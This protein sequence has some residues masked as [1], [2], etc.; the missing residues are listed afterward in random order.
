M[1]QKTIKLSRIK[2][3]QEMK[4]TMPR[5]DKLAHK[6]EYYKN[7]IRVNRKYGLDCNPLQSSIILDK[8]NT[9]LDGYTSYLI[10]KMFDMKK[11]DVII[12]E[13]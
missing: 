3:S 11:V 7:K 5:A 9:L 2:I 6:Y 12:G 10:A 13:K 8:H 1:K 4:S